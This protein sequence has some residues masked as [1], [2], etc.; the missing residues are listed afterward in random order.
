MAV[1]SGYLAGEA[2]A[3]AV[4]AGRTDQQAL[5][6]YPNRLEDSY[7]MQ[8]LRNYDFFGDF[9]HDEKDFIFSELPEAVAAAEEEFYR[10][11][12]EPK[13]THAKRARNIVLRAMGG[14]TGAVKKAWKYR[15]LLS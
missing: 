5:G 14:W 9:A 15:K 12:Y 6:A 8:N 13:E 7:V 11:D 10:Q 1:E 2:V 3:E 4:E